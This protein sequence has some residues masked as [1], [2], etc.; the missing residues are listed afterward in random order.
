MRT[1]GSWILALLTL[2]LCPPAA[3]ADEA[4]DQVVKCMEANVPAKTSVQRIEFRARDRLGQEQITRAKIS[5]KRFEDGFRR[6]LLH[7]YEPPDVRGSALLIFEKQNG[8][9][10][11]L[12]SPELKRTRRIS[13]R[14]AAGSLFGTDFS[15]EDFE[16]Y[17]G[18][19]SRSEAER[20]PDSVLGEQPVYV[21]VSTPAPEDESPYES[22][23]SF[24]SKKTCVALRIESYEPGGR[25]RKLITVDPSQLVQEGGIWVAQEVLVKDLRDETQTLMVIEEIEVDQPLSDKRFRLAELERHRD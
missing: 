7:F 17:Q 8:N 1:P 14:S 4:L 15:Y 5:G 13:A 25:L 21:L 9:D 22:V 2:L 10:M 19:H 20:R 18:I 6:L 11:F 23:V 24:V 3:S 12:Y 16:R